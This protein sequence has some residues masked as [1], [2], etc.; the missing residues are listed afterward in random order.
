MAI[1]EL[2]IDFASIG[3]T[4]MDSDLRR[5]ESAAGKAEAN[6]DQ[7]EASS[8]RLATTM[9]SVAPQARMAT[10]SLRSHNGQLANLTAQWNDIGVMMAA[11]QN[12]LQLALQQGTQLNQ[13]F[14]SMGGGRVALRA[15]GASLVSMINPLS[16]ATIGIIALGAAAVQWFTAA[17]AEA[18][19]LE[20]RSK[21]LS[22]ALKDYVA[23][24]ELANYAT[25]D[26][27]AKY[28]LAATSAS[29]YFASLEAGKLVT[30]N[31]RLK[32]NA[33]ILLDTLGIWDNADGAFAKEQN[34]ADFFGLGQ[35]S[36]GSRAKELRGEMQE[37]IK[38]MWQYRDATDMSE[39][40]A[41]LQSMYDMSS[42]LADLDG[43]R[44]E[45]EIQFLESL[46]AQLDVVLTLRGKELDASMK[47]EIAARQG[48]AALRSQGNAMQKAT[49]DIVAGYERQAAM[50]AAVARFGKDSYQVEALRREE[51]M[52][53]AEELIKQNNLTGT[54]ADRIREAAMEAYRMNSGLSDAQL[55]MQ[56][57]SS[58]ADRAAGAVGLATDQT[59]NWEYA[60]SG[61]LAQ[62][63]GIASVLASIGGG[64][65]S[66]ASMAVERQA[67]AAGASVAEAR[68]EVEKFNV[69]AKYDGRIAG[70]DGRG[71]I[72]GWAEAAALR[73]A[74]AVELGN[75]EMATQT[76]A[77]RDNARE[78]ERAANRKGKAAG[79]AAAKAEKALQKETL[80]W[81]ATLSPIEKYQQELAKLEKLRGRLSKAEF[82][83]AVQHLNME[84]ADSLP[85]VGELSDAVGEFV[86]SGFKD[87]SN[88]GDAFKNMLKQMVAAAAKEQ[89]MIALGFAPAGSAG[90]VSGGASG[91]SGGILGSL[92]SVFSKDSWLMTGLSSGKGIL[93][94]VGGWL[95]IG[96][97]AGAAGVA[98][99]SGGLLGSL[100][101]L[102]SFLGTAGA[103][104]GGI[105]MVVSIGKKLFGRELKDTG[106]QGTFSDSGFEGSTYKYYKGGLLRSN[107]TTTE[108]LDEAT[109]SVISQAYK[110]LRGNIKAMAKTLDLGSGAMAKF[111]YEFKISTKG[112]SEEEALQALQDEMTKA[113]A[114][115]A[116]LVLGTDK[117]TKAGETALDVLTRLS[118]SLVA[119]NA[120]MSM[121]NDSFRYSGLAGAALASNLMDAFGGIEQFSSSMSNYW[122]KFYS[123]QER[124]KIMT[125]QATAELRKYG[126]ALPQSRAEYR[127]LIE[128]IDLGDKSTHELYATLIRMADVMDQILPAADELTRKLERLQNRFSNLL[129]RVAGSLSEAIQNNQKAAEDWRKVSEGIGDYL[130]KLRGTVSALI[131][132]QQALVNN[133]RN[134]LSTLA[135]ARGGD[136][137]AA[138]N[139]TGAADAYLGSV[140]DTANTRFE[141]ALAQARVMAQL[142]SIGS[143]AETTADKLDRVATLQQRQLDLIEK[144]QELL[145]QG[146]T[147]S[148][149]QLRTLQ[150]KLG[151]LDKK[152]QAVDIVGFGANVSL[153]PEGQMNRLEDALVDLRK[154]IAAETARQE[155]EK[156]TQRLNT[157]VKSLTANRAGNHFVGDDDLTAMAKAIGL[158]TTGMS[159]NQVRSRLTNFNGNDLL[160][161]TVYDPTGALEKAYLDSLGGKGG[162]PTLA[163]P[164]QGFKL[165]YGWRG[166]Q[167][168]SWMQTVHGPL[169]GARVFEVGTSRDG[170]E[171]WFKDM[172]EKK[173]FPAFA[174]GGNHRGGPAYI[175][176][177][178]L[179]LVAPSRIYNPSETRSMLDN[180]KVVEELKR[181][182]TELSEFRKE[183]RDL[184][185]QVAEN[186]RKMNAMSQKWDVTGVPTVA[187]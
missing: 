7:L 110:E 41:A 93:G 158:D 5:V 130:T 11:G 164:F 47:A 1:F 100:G 103:I 73:T 4:K 178:D 166:S 80:A 121:L 35:V 87:F 34:A 2:G 124:V 123:E 97:G 126:H 153:L 33:Q 115:M 142:G 12:P 60:A 76:E 105:G 179:E 92:G 14:A 79:G 135:A 23:T 170:V 119:A 91:S 24:Q 174:R 136:L 46:E 28:G 36:W 99:A 161:G 30:L 137:S 50:G 172:I 19:T 95:G 160:K 113:G 117:Y 31:Q 133:R 22:S 175:G 39:R 139:L 176:E 86:A 59:Y 145:A 6:V 138:G 13:V 61:V 20:D 108:A 55:V 62:I 84:L 58:F 29:T 147:L 54:M 159:V 146:K 10:D 8:R 125:R 183:N 70:A 38:V 71:G 152:I 102:G 127:A 15:V 131:S 104:L 72:L 16:I 186:T 21:E 98:G 74:K 111:V 171:E 63:Q 69:A 106:L 101:S 148:E 109:E 187:L 75:I 51:A 185:I 144:V 43:S 78:A 180:T 140:R 48:Y 18:K 57:M 66:A 26:A 94:T 134:Y 182:K 149:E 150:E 81:Q 3:A 173:K 96:Q 37:L 83:Q 67:L 53:T 120:A 40:A 184:Q 17:G 88:L 89:I 65:I 85:L 116:E 129:D 77:M 122:D 168:G 42:R 52:R 143:R 118:S 181:L 64:L 114:G 44:S 157:Y 155:R 90:A 82:D 141:A 45:A 107:K 25:G 156:A 163:D 165:G 162:T 177:N 154:A 49:D 68:V 56:T 32:E 128:S 27:A 132:P 112:M 151:L 9:G 167:S 169:G